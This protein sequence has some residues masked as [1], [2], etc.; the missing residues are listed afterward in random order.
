MRRWLVVAL[1]IAAMLAV[2]SFA[3]WSWAEGRMAEGF[4]TWRT[5]M[6][7]QGWSVTMGGLSRG[8]W[9]LA[10]ELV[11]DDLSLIGG[12]ASVGYSA[13][14]VTMRVGLD[15]PGAL[16]VLFEGPQTLRLGAAPALP[17]TADRLGL[18]IPLAPGHPPTEAGLDGK[19]LSFAAPAEGLTVGL[20]EARADWSAAATTDLRISTEAITLPPTVTSPLGPHIASATV[21]GTFS[22]AIPMDA[23]TPAV[24][25]EEWRDSG[26]AITLRRIAL[27]W[28]PLGVSGSASARLDAA[29]RPEMTAKLRLVG[30]GETLSALAAARLITP[31][32]ART[33]TAVAT[34]LSAAPKE[35][36]APGV[37][38]PLT[39]RDGTLSL[40]VVPLMTIGKLV[41]PAAPGGDKVA[42]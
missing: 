27:G 31:Q 7:A 23:A 19:N 34:L 39:L 41:W 29:S 42:P 3:A 14:R 20:L 1:V 25:A 28:G 9:P 36:G 40:G 32:A 37:E 35:G 6:A 38:V 10:A 13:G 26:G 2:A 4:T 8:G 24:A 30:L 15:E 33:A 17:F 18:T 12:E 11:V 16:R 21:D 5:R 22:G